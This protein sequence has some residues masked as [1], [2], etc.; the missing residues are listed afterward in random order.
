[1]GVSCRALNRSS[2]WW[3]GILPRPGEYQ[4]LH[5]GRAGRADAVLARLSRSGIRPLKASPRSSTSNRLCAGFDPH[6]ASKRLVRNAGTETRNPGHDL[7]FSAPKSLSCA[8]SV[9]DTELRRAIEEKHRAA[10]K[11]ALSFLEE[12]C[13]FARI[14]TDGLERVKCPLIFA[15]F[16]H[17]T[18]RAEDQQL[19]THA[20][21]INVTRHGDGRTTAVDPTDFY[22]WKMAGGAVYRLVLGQGMLELGAK[23]K[24]RQIGSSIGW[25]LASIPEAW[26]DD[27]SKRRAE[28]EEKLALRKGSLDAADSRYAELVAKET[29]RTKNTEK[30]RDELFEKW[31]R[32]GKEHGITPEFLR[33]HFQPGLKLSEL[34]PEIRDARKE[35]LWK[36]ATDALSE[37]HSHWNEAELTKALAERAVGKLGLRDIRE[38][39][40]G[41]LRTHDLMRLGE[42]QTEKPNQKRHQYAEKWEPRFTTKEVLELEKQM[43]RD[44]LAIKNQTRSESRK[45]LIERAI[46]KSTPDSLTPSRQR[47]CGIFFLA[48]ES[49]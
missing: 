12:K 5:G 27:T 11:A 47:P 29:R 38:L 32:E 33:S 26:I 42:I 19:H 1:M 10:V 21:L 37:Q 18:S 31:Q 16:D 49:A 7:T 8:W 22:R 2:C 20:L 36:E 14:G 45:D 23:L 13:G 48:T 4:L 43:L 25:E 40:A 28:I 3:S 41:K 24:E 35:E 6:D 34:S 30:P 17:G 46:K 39:V 9:A 15:L 44:V